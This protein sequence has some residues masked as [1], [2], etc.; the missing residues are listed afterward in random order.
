MT[1]EENFNYKHNIMRRNNEEIR[2][3]KQM[4]VD[5]KT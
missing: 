3:Q 4:I 1:Y 5:K 2:Q